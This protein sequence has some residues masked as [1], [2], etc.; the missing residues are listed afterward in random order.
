MRKE[1]PRDFVNGLV[2]QCAENQPDF[3]P[4]KRLFPESCE[5]SRGRGI[6]RA[7]KVHIWIRLNFLEP[8]RPRSVSNSLGNRFVR[9][10]IPALLKV[11]RGGDGV[12]AVLYLEFAWQ[13]RS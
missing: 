8:A 5:F 11:A 12:E 2:A 9:N 6:V 3:S 13:S 4:R 10:L 1:N 7:I